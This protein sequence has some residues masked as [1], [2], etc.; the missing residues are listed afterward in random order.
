MTLETKQIGMDFRSLIN[1]VVW[2]PEAL[3]PRAFI[4]GGMSII[5]KPRSFFEST[6]L[7]RWLK[8]NFGY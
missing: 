3:D 2:R 5:T 8:D 4:K 6:E 7:D 1:R